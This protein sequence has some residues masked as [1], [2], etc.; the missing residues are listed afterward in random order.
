[1]LFATAKH[2]L[3]VPDVLFVRLFIQSPVGCDA[4]ACRQ[5]DP[6][7]VILMLILLELIVRCFVQ[8]LG[9][10]GAGDRGLGPILEFTHDVQFFD[11]H[12][13]QLFAGIVGTWKGRRRTNASVRQ[14]NNYE[15]ETIFDVSIFSFR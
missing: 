8:R 12:E 15:Q 13:D 9:M 7:Q 6:V 11:H 2:V 14:A 4:R 1:M 5:K 3:L 10:F